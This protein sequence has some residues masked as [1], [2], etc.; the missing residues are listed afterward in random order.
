[1]DCINKC[2]KGAITYTRRKSASAAVSQDSCN[3]MRT[4][5]VLLSSFST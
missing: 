3:F 1:M 4:L 5:I 2:R